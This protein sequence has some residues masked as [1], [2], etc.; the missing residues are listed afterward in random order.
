MSATPLHRAPES[1]VPFFVAI[2]SGTAAVAMAIL[3]FQL[4]AVGL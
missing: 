2:V 1:R 3:G 4:V